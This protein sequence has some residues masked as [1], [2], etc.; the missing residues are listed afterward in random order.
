[1]QEQRT[2]YSF[3]NVDRSAR[4]RWLLHELDIPFQEKRIDLQKGEQKHEDYLRINPFGT[5]PAL[6]WKGHTLFESG[7]ICLYLTEQHPERKLAPAPGEKNRAAY[8]QWALFACSSLEQIV[9]PWFGHKQFNFPLA[10]VE[11]VEKKLDAALT[12]LTQSLKGSPYV[13]GNEFSTA[14]ILL[15]YPL[16][17]LQRLGRLDAYPELKAYTARLQERPA[18]RQAEVFTSAFPKMN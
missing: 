16:S 12:T 13:L 7:A 17:L 14:D 3:L 4:V 1:M 10:N 6:E 9:F 5:I 11:E 2:L 15:S 18:A 8:L